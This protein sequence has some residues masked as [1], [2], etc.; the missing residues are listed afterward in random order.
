M[1]DDTKLT[2]IDIK[3]KKQEFAIYNTRLTYLKAAQN[4]VKTEQYSY[5]VEAYTKYL[6]ILSHYYGTT[7]DKLSPHLFDSKNDLTELLLISHA[8]WDLA[9][10]FDMTKNRQNDALRALNQFVKFSQGFKFQHINAQIIRKYN[11]KK[12]AFNSRAFEEAYSKLQISSKKCYIATH[13]FGETHPHT[14]T[15]RSFKKLIAPY[16]QGKDFIDFYYLFS[17]KLVHFLEKHTRLNF[18]FTH[19][20]AKPTLLTV[21]FII[22]KICSL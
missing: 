7:E 21:T 14:E 17:P 8:Y 18:L 16:E 20:L 5:A 12:K 11:I 9:K 3:I 2:E 10:I 15:L 22:K 4:F 19:F 13:C 6:N 1:S